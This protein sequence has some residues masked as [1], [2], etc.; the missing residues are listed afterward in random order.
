MARGG[1]EYVESH[2]FVLGFLECV[3]APHF[4][5]LG[6]DRRK[7]AAVRH[8]QIGHHRGEM[9]ER[10]GREQHRMRAACARDADA[11]AHVRT[12]SINR[13]FRRV[14][15]FVEHVML[16]GVCRLLRDE[17][18]DVFAQGTVRCIA[19]MPHG[20]DEQAL[21]VGECQRQCIEHCGADGI[22]AEPPVTADALEIEMQIA[23]HDVRFFVGG[24][25]VERHGSDSTA[26]RY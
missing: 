2:G 25:S 14:D 5:D 18:S 15:Q 9:L 7:Q 20:V 8:V 12:Y 16:A 11:F 19:K 22:P 13:V 23:R 17:F 1:Q 21:A 24:A 10:D 4:G 3:P 6:V 26:G